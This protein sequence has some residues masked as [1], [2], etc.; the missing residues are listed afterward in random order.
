[1]NHCR[2]CWSY[3]IYRD[4]YCS[5]YSSGG[6]GCSFKSMWFLRILRSFVQAFDLNALAKWPIFLHLLYFILIASLSLGIFLCTCSW[7][8][9]RSYVSAVPCPPP[10]VCPVVAFCVVI[11]AW[12]PFLFVQ[13]YSSTEMLWNYWNKD[14]EPK[15][16]NTYII[17]YS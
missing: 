2:F 7:C 1:M 12:C 13:V 3:L 16:G 4:V 17:Y 9:R 5:V 8:K 11:W 6:V 14:G 10:S 15:Q